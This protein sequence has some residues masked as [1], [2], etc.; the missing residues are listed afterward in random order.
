MMVIAT[1]LLAIAFLVF[2]AAVSV[3]LWRIKI[4]NVAISGMGAALFALLITV[5]LGVLLTAGMT[6][7]IPGVNLL[8]YTDLHLS[9]GML[10]WVALLLISVSYQVVP[11]FL[12]TPEYPPLLRRWLIPLLLM[13]LVCW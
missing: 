1:V 4:P 5:G 13:V 10:G 7:L 8:F 3:A 2:I 6:G 9:W 12:V 11:M